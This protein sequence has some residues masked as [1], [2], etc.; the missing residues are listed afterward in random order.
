MPLDKKIKKIETWEAE[1][2]NV[3]EK[4]LRF[5]DLMMKKPNKF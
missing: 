1:I 2:Q 4:K 3:L 5:S